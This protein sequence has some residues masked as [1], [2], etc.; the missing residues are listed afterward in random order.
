MKTQWWRYAGRLGCLALANLYVVGATVAYYGW[1]YGP[2]LDTTNYW[3][4]VLTIEIETVLAVVQVFQGIAQA[5]QEEAQRQLDRRMLHLLEAEHALLLAEQERDARLLPL[6]EGLYA[7]FPVDAPR[8]V[9][10]GDGVGTV[11]PNA[12]A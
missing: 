11:E 3:I 2:D 12:E 10:A 9:V 1:G 4:S 5:R 7:R 8:P 6:I